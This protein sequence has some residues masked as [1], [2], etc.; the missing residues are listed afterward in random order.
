M[1]TPILEI[2]NLNGSFPRKQV[3]HD[4]NLTLQPGRK[5]ALVGE[6]QRQNRIVAR[7][8]AP[9]SMVTFEGS[10]K[11]CGTD[12]LTQPERA[13]KKTA[14]PRNRHGVSEPMTA[15]NPVMRVG[16]QIAE[17]LSCIWV[18]I[19]KT[20]MGARYRT[21]RRN[22]HPPAR[23]KAQTYPFQLSGG[24]RQR[25]MIAM[26]VSAQPKLLIADEPTTAG[27]CRPSPNPRPAL[28]PAGRTRHDHV[29]ITHD[30][31]LVRRFTDDVAVM[32]NGRILETGKQPKFS[33]IRSTNTPKCCSMPAQRA[34]SPLCL[35]T[36]LPS[37]RPNKS[38]SPSKNQTAG[39]KNATKPFSTPFLSISN[40][41]NIGHH[42]RKW[43]RQNHAGKAV[44]H[45]IDS[46]AACIN[47]ESWQHELRRE[48]KWCS[49]TR[50]AHSIPRMNVFDTVSEAL[51][52]HEPSMPREEM[53]R[54]VEEVLKQV[55]LPKDALER[56]PHA[57]SGGQR[58]RSP[59][60]AP[61]LSARKSSYWTNQQARLM[62]NGNNKSRIAQRPQKNTASPS[63]SSAR[64]R[65]HPRHFPPRD[66]VE[67][68][69]NR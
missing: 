62:S 50:S 9:K 25:A 34:A 66:G 17:V 15:L 7:H 63:S 54:R 4:I 6:W 46:K 11:Y 42:R 19:K 65:R 12:L 23:A 53:R 35:K 18:W 1:T 57:F 61:S 8:Y 5:L 51:R 24:Q 49:K 31:N 32:R 64:P 67:R 55:G 14:R 43:L 37:L 38:P 68:R 3:L 39:F 29:Y 21:P 56:Y 59:S 36:L 16:E 27:R 52:V 2:E 20:G 44:M 40:R 41:G 10:L 33:P 22:R 48:I 60:P 69:Q 58:Q 13:C 28:T 26:A 45:L 47:G 30:L